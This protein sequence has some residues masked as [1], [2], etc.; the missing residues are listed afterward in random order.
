VPPSVRWS[1]VG[2]A[3]APAVIAGYWALAFV[4]QR[5]MLFPAP[6][7]SRGDP[8]ADAQRLWLET[9]FGRVEA[10]FLP[11]LGG[12]GRRPLLLFTHGNAELIDDWAREFA[13]AR[14]AGVGVLLV[15]YPGYGRSEGRPSEASIAA[16]VLAAY[17]WAAGQPSVDPGRIVAHGRSLGGGAACILASRRPV[18]ALVLES[19]FTGVAPMARRL[20]VPRFLVRDRFDNLAV[21]RTLA[22]PIL[23][24]HGDHD[25]VIP[26]IHGE[27]LAS[28][29]RRA[30]LRLVPCGHNDCP[31]SWPL[32][33]D[34]LRASNLLPLSTPP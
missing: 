30:T 24:I 14:R 29:A 22:G 7:V 12:A 19:T 2:L 31:S 27:R 10:W 21:V 17:D 23:V 32:V 11:G 18:A 4:A 28:A 34:F 5:P 20:G 26:T 1:L 6:R 15:E 13:E 16:A 9:G 33:R 25:T 8:P 3:A